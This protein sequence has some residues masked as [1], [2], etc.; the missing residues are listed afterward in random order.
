M[1]TRASGRDG[2]ADDGEVDNGAAQGRAGRRGARNAKGLIM[3]V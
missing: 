2:E 1:L 3:R